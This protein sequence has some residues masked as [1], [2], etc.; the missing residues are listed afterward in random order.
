MTRRNIVISGADAGFGPGLAHAFASRG[1][2]LALFG[3]DA[4][5]LDRIRRELLARYPAVTVLAR[6][7][8][9]NDR[10]AVA[11]EF[12]G[13]AG[14]LGSLDRVIL[15]VGLGRETLGDGNGAVTVASLQANVLGSLAQCEGAMAV[16]AHQ[17]GGHLVLMSSAAAFRGISGNMAAYAASKAAVAL[18]AEALRH[19]AGER[20][21]T[22]TTL[23][24][25][26]G[27]DGA[28]LL[29]DAIE[30]EPAGVIVPTFPW[31]PPPGG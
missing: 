31:P 3:P 2:N 19:R 18:L 22:V 10:T 4:D 5:R 23:Y 7:L 16:M 30:R 27:R 28:E 24:S 20:P 8:D 11:R 9:G 15:D 14:K 6:P 25:G 26:Y 13:A 21:I 1:R 17:G 29:A 12:A